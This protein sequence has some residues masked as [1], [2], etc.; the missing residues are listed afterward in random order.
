MYR[1]TKTK[2]NGF[3]ADSSEAL[4]KRTLLIFLEGLSL[5]V[6]TLI[7]PNDA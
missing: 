3:G 4:G 2:L 1:P 5:V 6:E 7:V